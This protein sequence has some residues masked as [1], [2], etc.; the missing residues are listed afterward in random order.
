MPSEVGQDRQAAIESVK[1]I[2][3]ALPKTKQL[4][5]LGELNEALRGSTRLDVGLL[6]LY[7]WGH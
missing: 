2:F 1:A 4:E 6:L 5:F 7:I 3:D